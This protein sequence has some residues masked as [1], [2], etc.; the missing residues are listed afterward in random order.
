MFRMQLVKDPL[1]L[2]HSFV[3]AMQAQPALRERMCLVMVGDGPMRAPAQAL[4]DSAGL[5]HMAWLPGERKDIATV[6]RAW[7]TASHDGQRNRTWPP[8]WAARAGWRSS[9]ASAWIP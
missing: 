3:Q 5:S 8:A 6:M 2:A 7:R 9:N 4:L 1:L